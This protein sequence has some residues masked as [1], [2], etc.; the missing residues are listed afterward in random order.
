MG[1]ETGRKRGSRPVGPCRR[2]WGALCLVVDV[3]ATPTA[4]APASPSI[5]SL[6]PN[7]SVRSGKEAKRSQDDMRRDAIV[8]ESP[9]CSGFILF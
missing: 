2:F 7:I 1:R 9:R 6:L 3:T 8:V 5:S 4:G